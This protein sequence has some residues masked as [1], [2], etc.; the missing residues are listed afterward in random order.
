M[1][2]IVVGVV[3]ATGLGDLLQYITAARLITKHINDSDICIGIAKAD[4]AKKHLH[5]LI[6]SKKIRII[7]SSIEIIPKRASSSLKN[8]HVGSHSS[9]LFMKRLLLKKISSLLSPY[10]YPAYARLVHEKF[11]FGV[12]GGHS[13]DDHSVIG[14]GVVSATT[15]YRCAKQLVKG[16]LITFPISI[17]PTVLRLRSRSIE[18]F[19]KALQSIDVIFVRGPFSKEVIEKFTR[20][21]CIIALDSSFAIRDLVRIEKPRRKYKFRVVIVPRKDYFVNFGRI[22]EY[23]EYLRILRRLVQT[24]TTKFDV[25]FTV[26][27]HETGHLDLKSLKDTAK[28]LNSVSNVKTYVPKTLVEDVENLASAD[29]VITCRLHAGIVALSY[30]VP[31]VFALPSRDVRVKDVLTLLGLNTQFFVLDFFNTK[32]MVELINRS[33]CILEQI[34]KFRKTIENSINKVIDLV[35]IPPRLLAKLL[36]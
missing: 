2:G 14:S 30:G 18:L 24:I 22:H 31:T 23:I 1:K 7:K 9:A 13:V 25:E 19:K 3:P 34:E 35:E 8:E 4:L 6:Q 16:P 20:R 10:F 32:E 26:T 11:D 5:K 36:E 21:R 29:L 17:T 33:L 28:T 12:I 15:F 27:V